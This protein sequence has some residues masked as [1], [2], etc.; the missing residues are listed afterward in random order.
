MRGA[1]LCVQDSVRIPHFTERNFFSDSGVTMLAESAAICDSITNSAVL[2]PWSHVK[3]TSRSPVV[4]EVCA[5]V[6]QAVDRRRTVK[7][8]Q[9]QRYAV[10]GIRPSSEDSASRSG[11]KISNIVKKGRVEYVNV[12]APSVSVPGPI[13]LRVSSGKSTKRKISRSP[14]KRRFEIASPLYH[15]NSIL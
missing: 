12:R 8:S 1:L 3:T 2:E 7:D 13:N 14:V 5:C 11:V 15:L 4:A 10:G 6:N 9:E